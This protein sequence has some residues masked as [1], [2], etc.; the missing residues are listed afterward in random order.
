MFI[1]TYFLL[2]F[3]YLIFY[4]YIYLIGKFLFSLIFKFTNE[5]KN[6]RKVLYTKVEYIYP[7]IGIIFLGNLLIIY[8]FFLPL[9]GSL[10][11][12]AAVFYW[13]PVLLVITLL[14]LQ[15]GI[16]KVRLSMVALWLF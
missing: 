16:S 8:N 4:G 6:P 9:N 1:G 12:L 7:L 2:L 15:T 3:K 5:N 11:L 10:Y 13:Q 14:A